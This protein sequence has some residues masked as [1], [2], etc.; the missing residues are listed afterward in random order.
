MDLTNEIENTNINYVKSNNL[1]QDAQQIIDTAQS[2]AYK[3]V[4]VA[5]LQ[6]N[7]FL[8]K[9]IVEE[10]LQG[11]ERAEYGTEVVKVLSQ[12]LTEIYGKGFDDS[13]SYRFV[14]FYKAFPEI[15]AT[16]WRKSLLLSWSH[17]KTL[18]QVKDSEARNWYMRE[19]AND[20]DIARYSILNGN[21]QL[22]ASKYKTYMPSEEELRAEIEAQKE[23]FAMTQNK[24][25]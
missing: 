17:Y 18:L 4:N 7:W 9:R 14:D 1:L 3:A 6:R 8:G 25:S 15:F 22:F 2:F 12:K 19:A 24:E 20:E 5:M 13:N 16:L 11:K 23:I 21:E 10:E